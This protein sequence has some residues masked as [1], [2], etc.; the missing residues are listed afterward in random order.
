M[1]APDC[2]VRSS[3]VSLA[4]LLSIIAFTQQVFG[5][6][7][8]PDQVFP[9]QCQYIPRDTQEFHAI[10]VR[11][12]AEVDKRGFMDLDT[13]TYL[14]HKALAAAVHSRYIKGL[15]NCYTGL[16]ISYQEK[17]RIDSAKFY[18]QL[19]IRQS[20]VCHDTFS[21]IKGHLGYGWALIYDHSDY[22][23]TVENFQVQ[24]VSAPL[25]FAYHTN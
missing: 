14:G 2:M 16:G 6:E 12:Q 5:Q 23:G 19:V 18:Y 3:I 9:D 10:Y 4:A 25:P 15:I 22:E 20:E 1:N 8:R 11:F 7:I 21:L 13:S 24:A 17:Y